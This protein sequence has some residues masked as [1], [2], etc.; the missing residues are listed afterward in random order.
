[1]NIWQFQSTLTRRLLVW[2][3]LSIVFGTL[4]QVPEDRFARGLGKQIAAWGFIDALIAIFGNQ[5]AKNRA[6][7]QPDPL[8]AQIVQDERD[9]LS[10]L[11]WVN[12]GLDVG[13]TTGGSV[14]AL[15]KGKTD[16]GWRGHGIGIIIQ[17]AFL[18]IF[19]LYHSIKLGLRT[20]V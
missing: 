18:F 17:G 12:T 7:R 14:L 1:M 6:A 11:L 8:A 10:K 13:Y 19:D 2:S 15:T 20:G 16:P 4:L 5:F 3:I 9:K